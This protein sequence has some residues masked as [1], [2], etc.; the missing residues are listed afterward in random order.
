MIMAKNPN[1]SPFTSQLP[2]PAPI[3][4]SQAPFPVGTVCD[5]DPE[6]LLTNPDV[7][8]SRAP[9]LGALPTR[10]RIQRRTR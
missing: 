5:G 2:A 8:A 4:P 7:P 1:W 6:D 9:K 10:P 3:P